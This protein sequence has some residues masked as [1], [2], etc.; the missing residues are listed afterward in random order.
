MNPRVFHPYEEPSS[1]TVT[2][3]S[4]YDEPPL[5]NNVDTESALE[6]DREEYLN[7]GTLQIHGNELQ[8]EGDDIELVQHV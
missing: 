7:A 3:P 2:A 1:G 6:S 4:A 8:N 5:P